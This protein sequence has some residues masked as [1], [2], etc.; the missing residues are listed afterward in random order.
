MTRLRKGKTR[1][2]NDFGKRADNLCNIEPQQAL[3]TQ[4][5]CDAWLIFLLFLVLKRTSFTIISY[6]LKQTDDKYTTFKSF[7]IYVLTNNKRACIITI[8]QY[9]M[10]NNELQA[11][12]IMRI[13]WSSQHSSAHEETKNKKH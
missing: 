1:T 12:I 5:H 4:V 10:Q 3:S 11:S 9:Y 7:H 8:L 13:F 6:K 2:L